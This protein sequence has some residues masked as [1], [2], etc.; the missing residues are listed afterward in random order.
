MR[1][2]VQT[3]FSRASA[4]SS[5]STSWTCSATAPC[6]SCNGWVRLPSPLP[7]SVSISERLRWHFCSRGRTAS[8]SPPP[9]CLAS[10]SFLWL[11]SATWRPPDSL[12]SSATTPHSWSSW[13]C[14]PS[15]TGTCRPSAWPTLHSESSTGSVA[16]ELMMNFCQPQCVFYL[17][18]CTVRSMEEDYGHD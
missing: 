5:S 17:G 6:P 16:L 15:P 2:F 14:S 4:A 7:L 18:K 9:C 12:S 11:C 8:C 3:K 13:P 1:L 10:S